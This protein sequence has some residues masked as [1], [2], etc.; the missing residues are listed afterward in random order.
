VIDHVTAVGIPVVTLDAL[1]KSTLNQLTEDGIPYEYASQEFASFLESYETENLPGAN[2]SISVLGGR[3][4]PRSAAEED[5]DDF[6]PALRAIYN[7]NYVFSGI[8]LNVA[9]PPVAKI[10]ANPFRRKT[11][12]N[13]VIGTLYNDFNYEVNFDNRIS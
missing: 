13:A 9:Q 1:F 11:L 3:L 12:V 6:M 10:A 4:L 5:I 2:V 7:S 8:A